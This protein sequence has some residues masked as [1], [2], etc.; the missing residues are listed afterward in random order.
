[1][2]SDTAAESWGPT[3]RKRRRRRQSRLAIQ[4]TTASDTSSSATTP[5]RIST[6]VA[7]SCPDDGDDFVVIEGVDART[8]PRLIDP[9]LT[10]LGVGVNDSEYDHGLVGSAPP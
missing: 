7:L 2:A 9:P 3:R 6:P 5:I 10:A 4:A 8:I 1:A